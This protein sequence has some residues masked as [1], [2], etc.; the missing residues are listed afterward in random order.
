MIIWASINSPALETKVKTVTPSKTTWCFQSNLEQNNRLK[1]KGTK[2]P[3]PSILK[4]TSIASLM[5]RVWKPHTNR[6]D[7]L[8]EVKDKDHILI[9]NLFIN[10]PRKVIRSFQQAAEQIGN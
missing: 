9:N 7:E 5:Q 4:G 8:R 3:K 2:R 10:T 1:S 6:K